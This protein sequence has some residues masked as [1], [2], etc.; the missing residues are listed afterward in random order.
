MD[1][2]LN[3]E[4]VKLDQ[5]F[6]FTI[7]DITIKGLFQQVYK[8]DDGET[9]LVQYYNKT[10]KNGQTKTQNSNIAALYKYAYEKCFNEPVEVRLYYADTKNR[11]HIAS[12]RPGYDVSELID[13]FIE[14]KEKKMLYAQS[15]SVTECRRCQFYNICSVKLQK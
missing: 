5:R 2:V 14:S 9:V 10:G 1:T 3:M 6:E 8:T 7:R 11:L 12:P 15:N 4:L 13:R